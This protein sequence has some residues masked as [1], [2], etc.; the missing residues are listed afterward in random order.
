MITGGAPTDEILDL[1]REWIEAE[2][3]VISEHSGNMSAD[4]DHL[5][6]RA[7]ARADRLNV[8]WSDDLVPKYLR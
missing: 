8:R 1:L 3:S 7:R 4:L 2:A 5:I 6:D